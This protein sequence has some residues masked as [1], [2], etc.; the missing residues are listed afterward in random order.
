[1]DLHLLDRSE[2]V[3][4]ILVKLFDTEKI[5]A[6]AKDEKPEART[7]LTTIVTELLDCDLSEA[8]SELV[9]DVLI[10]LVSRATLD[11]RRSLAKHLAKR[12]NVPLTL[13]I[14]MA[15]DDIDVAGE[16]LQ[17][18]R[19]FN[20]LDLTYIINSKTSEYWQRI[21]MRAEI[22]KELQKILVDTHDYPTAH[23]LTK[24]MDIVLSGYAI[25]VLHEMSEDSDALTKELVM[26]SELP[27]DLLQDIYRQAG[28]SLKS[29][30]KTNPNISETDIDEAVE[31]EI[32]Q[33]NQQVEIHSVAADIPDQTHEDQIMAM[34]N[35][36]RAGNM[37][38]FMRRFAEI[39]D[40]DKS[41][42][43]RALEQKSAKALAILCK[44]H[45]IGKADFVS[46][47]LL[48]NS[49]RNKGKMV[50]MNDMSCA[51]DYY[52]RIEKHDAKII[53]HK[54]KSDIVD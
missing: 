37:A 29:L 4:P 25:G 17:H 23:A 35:M 50:G 21:A 9:A 13:A 34:M 51:V 10:Q 5:Y 33:S 15:N 11:L 16:M 45:D 19:V 38:P 2:T 44:A 26:R 20:D 32:T 14:H 39:V 48:T 49:L 31:N 3:K 47:F 52:N 28:N 40:L 36:L 53:F 18:S 24:N 43:Q 7:E 41:I 46:M 1:M 6:L 8:E 22:S 42:I 30:M 27:S 54:M 12:D